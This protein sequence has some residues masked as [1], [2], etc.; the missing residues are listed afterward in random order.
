MSH[1]TGAVRFEHDGVGYIRFYEY[2]GTV[3]IVQP[4][5]YATAQDL[6]DNW[7]KAGW[8]GACEGPHEEIDAEIMTTY[9][10]GSHWPGRI[11]VKCYHVTE[12][13]EPP[14]DET[15]KDGEPH[16]SPWYEEWL[17]MWGRKRIAGET[18]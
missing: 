3:D 4:Q 8:D 12:G 2:N 1:S 7:R 6:S 17:E 16:W 5:T 14:C 10:A 13:L 11:C 18:D 15:E 9:G